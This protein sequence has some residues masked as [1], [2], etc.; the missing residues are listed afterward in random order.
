MCITP[1][2]ACKNVWVGPT[3][4]NGAIASRV[5]LLRVRTLTG[6]CDCPL[7]KS[8]LCERSSCPSILAADPSSPRW[9]NSSTTSSLPL[10]RS[11]TSA[12][13][14]PRCS[15]RSRNPN[16]Y[17]V[18]GCI[19][20]EA[21]RSETESRQLSPQGAS[22]SRSLLLRPVP[23]S[24]SRSSDHHTSR[25]VPSSSKRTA[26]AST[27][28]RQN[29]SPAQSVFALDGALVRAQ[30]SVRSGVA[31]GIVPRRLHELP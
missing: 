12:R 19:R 27:Q 7:T 13:A 5:H 11:E 21:D 1:L 25:R 16:F 20:G 14:T 17:D 28:R 22:P 3:P 31:G 10:L 4:P 26:N 8:G 18:G 2:C 24:H 9:L 23:S 30:A 6:H 29:L 15:P